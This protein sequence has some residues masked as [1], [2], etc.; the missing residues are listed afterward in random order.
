MATAVPV[1]YFGQKVRTPSGHIGTVHHQTG[2]M[3]FLI[4]E[5]TWYHP[6]K[7]TLVR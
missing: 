7:L 4:G 2:S 6:A 5:F 1:F 3:V